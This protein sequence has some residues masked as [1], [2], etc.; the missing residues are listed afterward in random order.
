MNSRNNHADAGRPG[1]VQAQAARENYVFA[2][3]VKCSF[4]CTTCS[5]LYYKPGRI[6]VT[7][8][9]QKW[10]ADLYL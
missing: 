2:G 8:D 3:L 10:H 7:F 4:I 6:E 5:W 1:L 9:G